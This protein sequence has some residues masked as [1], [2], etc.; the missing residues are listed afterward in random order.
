MPSGAGNRVLVVDD[1]R[2]IADTL[3]LILNSNGF[4]A[5]AA[6]SGEDAIELAGTLKPNFLVSDVIM[7]GMSGI[8]V[9]IYFSNLL[10]QC[11]IVLISGNVLTTSLLEVAGR[12]GYRFHVL[13]KPVHPHVLISHLS[14]VAPRST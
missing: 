10:P 9:A 3:T 8:E 2:L 12:Q 6:Y 4:E 11:K 1:E 14:S 13:P 7:G 5:H